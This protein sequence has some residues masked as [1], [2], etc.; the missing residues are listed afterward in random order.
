MGWTMFRY[1]GGEA[2]N[3]PCDGRA[4]VEVQP[5]IDGP[6]TRVL[7]G[8]SSGGGQRRRSQLQVM[9]TGSRR[10]ER[11]PA[12]E[13]FTAPLHRVW[14]DHLNDDDCTDV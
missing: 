13:S 9:M 4:Q 14:G 5:S 7:A 6:W 2:R 1:K 3:G 10:G 8:F 11:A 12:N